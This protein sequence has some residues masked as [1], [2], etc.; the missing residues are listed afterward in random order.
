MPERNSGI[1]TVLTPIRAQ[2]A[3]AIAERLIGDAA[4]RLHQPH[5][6]RVSSC[7]YILRSV[8]ASCTSAYFNVTLFASDGV[9]THDARRSRRSEGLARMVRGDEV[10]GGLDHLLRT[11]RCRTFRGMCAGEQWTRRA[12]DLLK[13]PGLSEHRHDRIRD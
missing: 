2:Q 11:S 1:E 9:A 3:N 7:R 8:R 10:L 13:R 12:D 6:P 5:D 4:P